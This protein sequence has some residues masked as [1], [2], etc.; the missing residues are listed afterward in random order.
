MPEN[1][2]PLKTAEDVFW[3][4]GKELLHV[5]I[6]ESTDCLSQLRVTFILKFY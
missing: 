5:A 3:E 6:L 2:P 1:H 4:S